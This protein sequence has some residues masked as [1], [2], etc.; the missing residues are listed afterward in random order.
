MPPSESWLL[1]LTHTEFNIKA[2]PTVE[3]AG[4]KINQLVYGFLNIFI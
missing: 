1:I 3:V 2:G 4:D